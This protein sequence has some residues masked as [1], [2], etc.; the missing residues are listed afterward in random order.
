MSRDALDSFFVEF[1]PVADSK[2]AHD[3]GMDEIKDVGLEGPGKVIAVVDFELSKENIRCEKLL[4]RR[5]GMFN[6]TWT[7]GG[8]LS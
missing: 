2:A 6:N 7:F 8:T 4:N 1:G 3:T 5:R